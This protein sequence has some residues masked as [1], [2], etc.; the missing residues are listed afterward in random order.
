MRFGPT[1]WEDANSDGYIY[2]KTTKVSGVCNKNSTEEDESMWVWKACPEDINFDD[3]WFATRGGG[4]GTW[5]VILSV[6]LQLHEDSGQVSQI[7]TPPGLMNMIRVAAKTNPDLGDPPVLDA[8]Y[9][10]SWEF[11]FKFMWQPESLGLL[12]DDSNRCGNSSF[13]YFV[14]YGTEAAAVFVKA[15]KDYIDSETASLL[16]MG[17]PQATLTHYR[18][19]NFNLFSAPDL[20]STMPKIEDGPHKGRLLDI[21][22]PNLSVST[23]FTL[24]DLLPK[25]CILENRDEFIEFFA[26]VGEYSPS[27]LYFAFGTN[28][29]ITH[30]QTASLSEAHREAGVMML[31]P[32]I[33]PDRTL[34]DSCYDMSN[35]NSF[36][37]MFGSNHAG[38]NHVG[39]LRSDW[40][41]MCPLEW[42]QE[43]RERE[44]I[45]QQEVIYGTERLARLEEIKKNIDPTYMFNCNKCIGNNRIAAPPTSPDKGP[46]SSNYHPLPPTLTVTIVTFIFLMIF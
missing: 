30:D 15:W 31:V 42:T 8:L 12:E 20:I 35:K 26:A 45:P 29:G 33:V 13:L 40:T 43:R 3:L 39:P 16:V 38:P 9:R 19:Y 23:E 6:H 21:P 4:G 41:Q 10:A 37:P 14:C 7:L 1:S 11:L 25:K 44:C 34:L 27:V 18:D 2:P 17:V 32:Q 36:P 24:N 28:P 5:G 22:P 46:H